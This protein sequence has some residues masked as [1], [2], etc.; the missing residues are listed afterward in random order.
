MIAVCNLIVQH[1][2]SSE[3]GQCPI[4]FLGRDQEYEKTIP[5]SD[6]AFFRVD[7]L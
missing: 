4:A 6:H 5:A 3:H 2:H 7:I 1:P